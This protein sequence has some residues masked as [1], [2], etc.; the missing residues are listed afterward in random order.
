MDERVGEVLDALSRTGLRDDTVV[1]FTADH[2][3]MGG[4][5]G[6]WFKMSFFEGSARVPLI[7]AGPGVA[8]GRVSEP[9]SHLDLA[10]TLAEI[11]GAGAVDAEFEGR[12]LTAALRT[13]AI[14]PA[15]VISEYLAEGVTAPAVMLRRGAHKYIRCPGDPDQLFDLAADPQEIAQSGGRSGPCRCLRGASCRDRRALGPRRPARARPAA[16]RRRGGS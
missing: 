1:A 13:G 14:A 9:V 11:A 8:A 6:L 3:E 2:G 4:E 16:A 5:R 15:T 7:V 12:S 10:P